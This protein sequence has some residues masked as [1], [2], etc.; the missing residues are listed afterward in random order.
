MVEY[1]SE[2]VRL[3][4]ADWRRSISQRAAVRVFRTH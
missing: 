3:L 4:A 1:V 2:N